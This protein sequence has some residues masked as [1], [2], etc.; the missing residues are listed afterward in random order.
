MTQASNQYRIRA[1][2]ADG[3][4]AGE[5]LADGQAQANRLAKWLRNHPEMVRV[6]VIK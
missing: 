4:L 3:K 5:Y 1:Y 2:Y 6:E